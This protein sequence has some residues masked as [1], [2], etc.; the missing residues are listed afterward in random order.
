MP[1]V[2]FPFTAAYQNK[3][4]VAAV[5]NERFF[6][7]TFPYVKQVDVHQ[8]EIPHV[9]DSGAMDTDGEQIRNN[10]N[11][12]S[13]SA[14]GLCKFV[15]F[16]G[17]IHGQGDE[18]HVQIVLVGEFSTVF[19]GPKDLCRQIRGRPRAFPPVSEIAG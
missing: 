5:F 11:G 13:G 2:E 16:I 14:Q 6:M 19:E 3:F 9:M 7:R 10:E 18:H 15:Y 1:E 8:R 12:N 17:R 4:L